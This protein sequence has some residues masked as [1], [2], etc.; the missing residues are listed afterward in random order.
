MKRS[1]ITDQQVVEACIEYRQIPFGNGFALDI[2]VARTGAPYKVAEAA[3]ERAD[4]RG[5]IDYGVSL[6]TAWA[7]EKG[8]AL[9]HKAGIR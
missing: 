8:R 3:M 4:D 9:L 7:T 2:L 5:L 1:D 6:R